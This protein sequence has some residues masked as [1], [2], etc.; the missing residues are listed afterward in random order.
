MIFRPSPWFEG[1]SLRRSIKSSG[2]CRR[3][4]CVA[5]GDLLSAIQLLEGAC[6][7]SRLVLLAA[8]PKVV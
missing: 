6:D 5:K 7:Q 4:A 1:H 3:N 2:A 8:L